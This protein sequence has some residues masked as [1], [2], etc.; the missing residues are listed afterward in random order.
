MDANT[1]KTNEMIPLKPI[2]GNA[3][4]LYQEILIKNSGEDYTQNFIHGSS[5]D[6]T[7]QV[8]KDLGWSG[9]YVVRLFYGCSPIIGPNGSSDHRDKFNEPKK[10][11]DYSMSMGNLLNNGQI[12][13][14]LS[15][16]CSTHKKC[17][18]MHEKECGHSSAT[19][20]RIW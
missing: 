9:K 8:N 11:F 10:E 2:I 12:T 19:C 15:G 17:R 6:Y 5:E 18:D 20:E 16:V 14:R 4:K 7:E 3:M 1:G 13:T